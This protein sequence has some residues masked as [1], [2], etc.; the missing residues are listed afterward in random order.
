MDELSKRIKKIEDGAKSNP[1]ALDEMAELVAQ[2]P[3]EPDAWHGLAY[4]TAL[5]GD[6]RSSV[7]A[8][9]RA[10]ALSPDE[11]VYLFDKA[12]DLAILGEYRDVIEDATLGIQLSDR[13]QF[14]SYKDALIFLRAY[15]HIELG[16]LDSAKDDLASMQDH[17]ARNWIRGLIT[18]EDLARRCGLIAP[19]QL[20]DDEKPTG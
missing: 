5:R 3:D 13:I 4:L 2:H 14:F 20:P 19:N 16:N 6:L 15:A 17:D 8:L 11:P 18:W 7:E 1:N 10:I 9:D 12:R